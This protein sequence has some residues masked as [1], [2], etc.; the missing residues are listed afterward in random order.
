MMHVPVDDQHTFDAMLFERVVGSDCHVA[1]QAETHAAIAQCVMPR[2]P[3]CAE[4]AQCAAVERHVHS[5]EHAACTC[6]CCIPGT[7]ADQ[8]I[9]IDA[10]PTGRGHRLHAKDIVA[11]V[12]KREFVDRCVS[13]FVMQQ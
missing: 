12:R 11:I 8:R 7:L 10:P 4:A 9:R 2:W 5:I 6:R 13:S 3:D 1:E